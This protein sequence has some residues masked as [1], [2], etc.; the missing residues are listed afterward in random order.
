MK[1]YSRAAVFTAIAAT[2]LCMLIASVSSCTPP[3]QGNYP[4]YGWASG[5]YEASSS[6]IASSSARQGQLFTI[7][8]VVQFGS[9]AEVITDQRVEVDAAAHKINLS[10]TARL[11]D[12]CFTCDVPEPIYLSFPVTLDSV[13]EWTITSKGDSRKVVVYGDWLGEEREAKAVDFFLRHSLYANKESQIRIVTE[14]EDGEY[15]FSRYEIDTD[16]D[17]KTM[18]LM[19]FERPAETGL[20]DSAWRESNTATLVFPSEGSWLLLVGADMMAGRTVNS[21]ASYIEEPYYWLTVRGTT[22]N[23][24]YPSDAA[25]PVSFAVP[26]G[27]RAGV[28]LD[29]PYTALML[30]GGIFR[31][32]GAD[33]YFNEEQHTIAAFLYT[34]WYFV[35]PG[36]EAAINADSDTRLI[37]P[38]SG[39]WAVNFTGFDGATFQANVTISE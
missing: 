27:A 39:D 3:F 38:S 6:I 4:P 16:I 13:G 29:C 9:R 1:R 5:P 10:L 8:A 25:L 37:F 23:E 24:A 12:G 36:D 20:P 18:R 11:S 21:E 35:N 31:S 33:Y 22:P 14:H 7:I 17:S 28:A 15:V 34:D 30:D 19:V 32:S 26:D 2:F